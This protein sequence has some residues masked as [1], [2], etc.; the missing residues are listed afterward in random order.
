[1]TTGKF[2]NILSGIMIGIFTFIVSASVLLGAYKGLEYKSYLA[3]FAIALVLLGIY[4]FT[5][6]KLGDREFFFQRIGALKTGI[7]LALL[8]FVVNLA[9]VL[10]VR[11]EPVVDYMTFW[12]SALHLA[13]D[14]AMSNAHYVA[15]F[16]H[17]LGYSSF[18]SVFL[19]IFGVHSMLAPVVNVVLTTVS[20]LAIYILC[21]RGRDLK[22]GVFAFL[23]W[24]FCP[25]K[26]MYNALVLSEPLYT[27][28]I[29]LFFLVVS[30]LQRRTEMGGCGYWLCGLAALICAGLLTLV[31]A[32]RPI[33]AVPL[34]AFFLWLFLLR[35]DKLRDRGLWRRWLAF[36]GV[37]V[38]GYVLLCQAWD[39]YA[40]RKLGEK[41]TDGYG[42]SISVGFNAESNGSYCQADM[43]LLLHYKEVYG[44]AD[45]AQEL[46]LQ[47]AKE[48]ISS[49]EI[50]FPYL[51]AKK[52]Q[53]FL[54][55]DEGGA[56]HSMAALTPLQYSLLAGISNIYYYFVAMLAVMGAVR[57]WLDK[58][59]FCQLMVPM[60]VIG[61]TL[62]QLLVEVAGR[63]H[64]SIIPMLVIMA[65]F[66]WG[67]NFVKGKGENNA[68]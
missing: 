59:T 67:G 16:P 12:I 2:S 42:Y 53:T 26:M 39:V 47:V 1:M 33:A 62:A 36:A 10:V 63:Y 7:F 44:S 14:E 46:L 3:A 24:T 64:Y 28:L 34:I 66:S 21:L 9:W 15:L 52:L 54:G 11:V 4:V 5:V 60:Y 25:S 13:R 20:G 48:R 35:G 50:N 19:K 17:I 57:I 49:G 56:F 8:C 27:C 31:N 18:L 55:N 22:T 32:S 68:A 45:V 65:A 51:M 40:E 6:K 41:P 38:L 37:M 58:K 30:Q 61:L 43:D 29:L 23:L